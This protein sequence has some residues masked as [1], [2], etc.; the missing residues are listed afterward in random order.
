MIAAFLMAMMMHYVPPPAP[1]WA[2]PIMVGLLLALIIEVTTE[3]VYGA[4]MVFEI[5]ERHFK[6][7][8]ER[9]RGK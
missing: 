3:L 9:Y 6:A 8:Q 5:T 1:W 4:A 7:W 2:M